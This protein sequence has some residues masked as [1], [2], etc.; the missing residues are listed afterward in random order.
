M[1]TASTNCDRLTA[2][3]T[4]ATDI[5]AE[6]VAELV[7]ELRREE[8]DSRPGN[9]SAVLLLK[10]YLSGRIGSSATSQRTVGREW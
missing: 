9:S 5:V 6:L 7:G 2:E 8:K 4:K 1:P 10:A 3:L